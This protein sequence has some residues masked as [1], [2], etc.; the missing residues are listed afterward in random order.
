MKKNT[1]ILFDSK[2]GSTKTLAQIISRRLADLEVP[3]YC[4]RIT[5]EISME[6]ATRVIVATPIFYGKC[7][8][9]VTDFLSRHASRLEELEIRLVFTCLRLTSNPVP[10]QWEI[11]TDPQLEES[12]KP[13][14]QM[15]MMEKSHSISH[16]L[17]YLEDL[18]L[19]IRPESLAFFKGELN[20]SVLDLK[21]RLVMK[22]MSMFMAQAAPGHYL[23]H[24]C[25]N[26]WVNTLVHPTLSLKGEKKSS[27]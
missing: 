3:S 9:T 15:G 1:L 13:F 5:H 17:G 23:N 10:T 16:Y 12:L 21:S 11:F 22:L 25:I 24:K 26:Q 18:L 27:I 8:G 20:F 2:S 19:K 6:G 14:K 7:P 4:T